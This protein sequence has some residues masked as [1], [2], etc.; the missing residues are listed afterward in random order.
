MIQNRAIMYSIRSNQQ[1]QPIT[2]PLAM[3]IQGQL[4]YLSCKQ[5]ASKLQLEGTESLAHR[6]LKAPCYNLCLRHPALTT[7]LGTK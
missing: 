1:Q 6:H 4:S 7:I 3:L 5:K 2:F